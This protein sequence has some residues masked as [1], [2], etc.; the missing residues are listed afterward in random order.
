MHIF[1]YQMSTTTVVFGTTYS[2]D[3]NQAYINLLSTAIDLEMFVMV[4]SYLCG[5]VMIIRGIAM[6]KAFG[7]NLNQATRPGEVAG[8][9]VYIVI[10]L[11][12]LYFP[13]IF[14]I[15]LYTIYGTTN[16]GEASYTG[17][18][19]TV[20]W[21]QIYNLITRYCRLIG[22][23]SFFR[24]LVLMS[25]SGEPGTQPGTITKGMIHLVAGIMIYNVWGTV[26]AFQYT[27]GISKA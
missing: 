14:E 16:L 5:L 23:I 20:D 6:Y 21:T 25:K 24:G 7:A 19:T 12:L 1:D 8:P 11:F 27:F 9:F 2:F 17:T 26:A 3:S 13:N 15:S 10:G 22:V 18:D 4:L